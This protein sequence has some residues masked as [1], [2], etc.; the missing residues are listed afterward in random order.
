MRHS[1]LGAPAGALMSPSLLAVGGAVCWGALM[2]PPA[3]PQVFAAGGSTPGRTPLASWHALM[4]PS[5]RKRVRGLGGRYFYRGSGFRLLGMMLSIPASDFRDKVSG[6]RAEGS[7]RTPS[8]EILVLLRLLFPSPPKGGWGL[9][10][11]FRV[12]WLQRHPKAGSSWPSW[13]KALY[14]SYSRIRTRSIPGVVLCS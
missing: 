10:C 5:S 11:R 2:S 8:F 6:I 12:Q 1:R 4:A 3:L 14:R 13:P 9:G 7:G